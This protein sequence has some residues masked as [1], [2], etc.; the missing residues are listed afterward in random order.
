MNREQGLAQWRVQPSTDL[1]NEAMSKLRGGLYGCGMIS[2]FHLRGWQRIHEVDIFALGNRTKSRAEERR[3]QFFPR[4]EVYEDLGVML[5]EARLDFVDIL[6]PPA[7]HREHCLLAKEAGLHIICQKPLCNDLNDARS[8]VDEMRNYPKLFAVHENHRYRPW[9]Q[10]VLQLHR[11]DFFGHI[12][13]IRLEHLNSTAPGEAYKLE[14]EPGVMLEYGTHL[15]DMMRALLGEPERV[16]ARLHHLNPEVRGESLFHAAYEYPQTTAIIEVAWK[17]LGA[18]QG[19]L[20]VAGEMGE[21]Y[22]EGTMTR[23]ESSRFRLFK[24][25]ATVLDEVRSP[26]NDYVESF[27]LFQREC[28]DAIMTGAA[29]R[30]TG[31]ENLR[32]L[33]GAFAAYDAA[34]T[35]A[36]IEVADKFGDAH[37]ARLAHPDQVGG[38]FD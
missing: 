16:Y 7:L 35:G 31:L 1:R 5:R 29:V 23:G 33:A 6:T 18:L 22:F 21:A 32:T 2:E 25:G 34:A 26:Y 19:S 13:F 14:A 27:Y 17:R 4:A 9:F 20:L 15:V 28:V 12:H 8:L 24:G 37:E 38:S 11:E 3:E 30:Q 36:V 10:Q